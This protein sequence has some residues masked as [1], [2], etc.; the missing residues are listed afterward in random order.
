VC[1]LKFAVVVQPGIGAGAVVAE[2]EEPVPTPA[3]PLTIKLP[4]GIAA[5]AVAPPFTA[6]KPPTTSAATE[7]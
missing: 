4:D 1:S 5:R 7:S 3:P 6:S 2:S